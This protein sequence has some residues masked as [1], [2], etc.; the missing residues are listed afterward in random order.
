M[1]EVSSS[2]NENTILVVNDIRDQ[3][4][5]MSSVLQKAGYTVITANDGLEGLQATKENM[6]DLVISDVNMPKL[7][8]VEFCRRLRADLH[9]QTIPFLLVSALQKDNESVLRGFNAGADDYLESPFAPMRL[10]AKVSRLIEK[11]LVEQKLRE[12]EANFR[13]LFDKAPVAYHELDVEGRYARVNQTEI[14]MLGYKVSEMVGKFVWDFVEDKKCREYILSMLKGE[15]GKSVEQQW[16]R[17]DG[18]QLYL[19]VNGLA[20][21][22]SEDNIVGA[23][24]TLQ[25]ITE[26][27][28]LEEQLRQAQ[29]LES[30]GQLSAGIAH[31]INTPT[32]FVGDN[33]RFLRDGFMDIVGVLDEYES[34]LDK[35]LQKNVTD[36]DIE[37]VK[38]E[39]DK[40]DVEYLKEEVPKAIKQ[41]LEG[42]ER[43]IKIV[44]SMKD[45]AHPGSQEK[46]SV[47]LNRSIESTITVASNEWKYIAEMQTDFDPTLPPV[48]CLVSEFNQV[49]LNII[50]NAVHAISDVIGKDGSQK[51]LIKISTRQTEDDWVEVRISDSGSGIEEKHRTRIFDPFYTT[52]EV[53]K[54]TGQGLGIAH[55]VIV[56]KHGGTINFETEVGRGTTFIIRL[57]MKSKDEIKEMEIIELAA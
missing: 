46:K 56:E 21:Y 5:L 24:F 29:K 32:Q 47:D 34:L 45:F 12:S 49:V 1:K 11:K 6:P 42:I 41:S 48:S 40:A 14:A 27:K 55:R 50:V 22:D 20:L 57:P 19:L 52:K 37:K 44:Q 15:S 30:I 7:D 33:V 10:I 28:Q 36:A 23:R 17:K 16:R 39:S 26:R 25:D 4:F 3:L 35:C 31:E 9:L 54:G 18:T 13:D 51:G 8:G 2:Q 53:G 43:I 38:R